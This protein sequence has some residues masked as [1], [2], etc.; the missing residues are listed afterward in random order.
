MEPTQELV[1]ALWADKVRAARRMSPA[2]K[3]LAGPRLFDSVRRVMIAG[4]RHQFP[5]ADELKV[6]AILRERLA[7]ARKLENR[8]DE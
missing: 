5:G 2:D 7:F 4:I 3:L 1:D 8:H 6:R